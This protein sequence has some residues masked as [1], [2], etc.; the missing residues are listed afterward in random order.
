MLSLTVR[1][2]WDG[3]RRCSEFLAGNFENSFLLGTDRPPP[4]AP[5][6]AESESEGPDF[7][8]EDRT[9]HGESLT[10]RSNCDHCAPIK[11]SATLRCCWGVLGERSGKEGAGNPC[12]I[13]P[14][15]WETEKGRQLRRGGETESIQTTSRPNLWGFSGSTPHT[16]ISFLL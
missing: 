4:A 9:W 3:L 5:L 11:A 15:K 13:L 2:M 1:G 6:Q 8:N 12:E 14:R 10:W 7:C 16:C